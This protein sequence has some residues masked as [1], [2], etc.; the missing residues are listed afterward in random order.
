MTTTGFV[1]F[2]HL[3]RRCRVLRLTFL[4]RLVAKPDRAF[5][6]GWG[7]HLAAVL[8]ADA[9]VEL[10]GGGHGL[11]GQE[12]DASGRCSSG[13]SQAATDCIPARWA[14]AEPQRRGLSH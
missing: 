14:R 12:L 3:L 6:A 8:L 4:D 10:G 2:S 9:G 1:I 11:G 7:Q 13:G 5:T